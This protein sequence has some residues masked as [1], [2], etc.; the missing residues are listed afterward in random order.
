[1]GSLLVC[2]SGG[3]TSVINASVV[4]VFLEGLKNKNIDR[5]YG[6]RFGISGI[7]DENFIEIKDDDLEMLETWK[8]TPSA[9]LGSARYK[10]TNYYENDYDYCRLHEIFKKYDIRYFFYIG[11]NDSMDTCYKINEYFK[12]IGYECSVIGIPK[13]IDNDLVETDHCPGYG[14]AAKYVATSIAEIHHD[15]SSYKEGRVTI[16]EIMGRD[17]GWLAASSSLAKINGEGPDLIYLCEIPFNVEDFLKKVKKIYDQKKKVLVAVS[18]GIRDKDG[19]YL[20]KYRSFNS[21]DEF[22]HLQLGG[23]ALV[24]CEIVSSRLDLPVR[25]IEL[26]LPQRC[27]S[28]IASKTDLEEAV[29]CGSFAVKEALKHTTGKMVVIKR[30]NNSPYEIEYHMVELEKVKNYVKKFPIYWVDEEGNIKEEYYHYALPL[31]N[32]EIMPKFKNGLPIF[33]KIKKN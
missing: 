7:F 21:D 26:S 20:L 16:V 2:Q 32:G 8:T 30:T 3:P 31:I 22:G 15:I 9:I 24:L 1:M 33:G 17:A 4:G 13:T 19:K 28:H 12:H 18:E 27:A 10:L 29:S 25:A 5:L 23:V 14:S 11:G 6:A